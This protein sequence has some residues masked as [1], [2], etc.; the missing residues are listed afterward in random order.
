MKN[1]LFITGYYPFIQGGAE[2][3][4]FLL[5]SHLKK[6]MNVSFVFRNRWKKKRVIRE[7]QMTLY[8]IE[9]RLIKGTN[10][11]F[12]FEKRQM[13]KILDAVQPDYIY[14]RG[15]NAYFIMA[16]RHAL[17]RR[18]KVIWHIASILDVTPLGPGDI[19][20]TP[21]FKRIEKKMLE[22][23][24]S[25]CDVIIAQSHD[26]ASLLKKNYARRC[27][28]IIRN[29]HPIPRPAEKHHSRIKVLW[30]ANWKPVKQ[31]HVFVELARCLGHLPHVEFTM[32]G[33]IEGYRDL[34]T[35][36][37]ENRIEV[38]GE[39]DN[40]QVNR[41]LSESHL[42]LNTSLSEGFSNTFVQAWMR[43][44]PVISLNLD[45]DRLLTRRQ[46]GLCSK[47]FERLVQDT[48]RLITDDSLR[49]T[50]SRKAMAY[51]FHHH[52]LENIDKIRCLLK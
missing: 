20:L 43:G 4:A 24:I 12:L 35:K 47:S 17:S 1:I 39:M 51:A 33:R 48:H 23:S 26:Q 18:C 2:Y 41:R 40:D 32:I 37:L 6:F 46:I 9:P 44:V 5:A 49:E 10:G 38:A 36:A 27:D 16:V 7:N 31:P 52:S 45:P 13:D 3:Q 14:V 22:Y 15:A 28:M 25:K 19:F 21:P 42:L 34:K 50:M 8:A 11:T 30:I 29:W